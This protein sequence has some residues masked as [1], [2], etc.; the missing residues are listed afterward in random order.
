[1][2]TEAIIIKKDVCVWVGALMKHLTYECTDCSE[3][4]PKNTGNKRN[5]IFITV[6]LNQTPFSSQ[7][8]NDLWDYKDKGMSLQKWVNRLMLL[9]I[10][11]S[12]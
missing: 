8:F 12:E 6:F 3:T 9:N 5:F 4:F 10:F 7:T 1:M 2:L 11:V